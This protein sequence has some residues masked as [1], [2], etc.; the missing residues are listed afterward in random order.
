MIWKTDSIHRRGG[1]DTRVR[2]RRVAFCQLNCY[3]ILN[4]HACQTRVSSEGSLR[5]FARLRMTNEKPLITAQRSVP[6]G[7]LMD[8]IS[9]LKNC[10]CEA[11]KGCGNLYRFKPPFPK[12]GGTKCRRVAI[13]ITKETPFNGGGVPGHLP[14][15]LTDSPSAD[16]YTAHIFRSAFWPVT[17]T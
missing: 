2:C 3:V 12:G 14:D 6:A 11:R 5:F 17:R 16:G 15:H 9:S 1:T 13:S 7:H 8:Q 10:H 4:W